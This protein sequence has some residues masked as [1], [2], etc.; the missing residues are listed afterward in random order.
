LL[1][2]AYA[3]QGQVNH[4]VLDYTSALRFIEQNWQ[5]PPL[6][7]RDARANS[8]T[9]A[10]NFTIGPRPPGLIPA[11][12]TVVPNSLPGVPSPS[13]PPMAATYL[14]YGTAAAGSVL[15]LLFAAWSPKLRAQRRAM[16]ARRTAT[17]DEAG[18]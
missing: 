14:L 8:L 13:P 17:R 9:S 15:L 1:I 3:R 18:T 11:G 7:S 16:A 5:L 10:F 12:P 6:T 4:T 2:S